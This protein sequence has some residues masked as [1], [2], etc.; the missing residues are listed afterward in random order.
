MHVKVL[1]TLIPTMIPIPT[2]S[3]FQEYKYAFAE[4]RCDGQ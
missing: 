3:A 4:L 2:I 1:V